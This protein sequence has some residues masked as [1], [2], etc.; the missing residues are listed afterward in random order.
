MGR[1]KESRDTNLFL[2]G[3]QE[4]GW[5]RNITD[6]YQVGIPDILGCHQ[7]TS[8]GI[9]VKSVSSIPEDGISPRLSEHRFTAKQV[10]ELKLIKQ[11]GGVA[12]GVII[13]GPHLYFGTPLQISD[14]GQMDCWKLCNEGQYVK[15][16]SG[17]WK[18]DIILR[19]FM[20]VSCGCP[21]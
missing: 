2:R 1:K 11:N 14:K 7:G 6:L 21:K 17:K 16:D 15:K 8:Y 3:I 18:I 13:C 9:E 19:R 4:V 12:V 10:E 20:E 5:F